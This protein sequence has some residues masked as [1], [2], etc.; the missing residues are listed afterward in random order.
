MREEAHRVLYGTS[1]PQTRDG[2][3]GVVV[4]VESV[5]ATEHDGRI[6]VWQLEA[7]IQGTDS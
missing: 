7:I 6:E 2:V 1:A 5:G 3:E 4:Q